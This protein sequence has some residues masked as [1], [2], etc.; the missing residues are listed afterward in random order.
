ME[1]Y[2]YKTSNTPFSSSSSSRVSPLLSGSAVQGPCGA[3]KV[4]RRRCTKSCLLAPY[5]PPTEPMKFINA[6][7]IYGASNIVKCLQELPESKRADA[8]SSMVYEANAR[9]RDPVYGCAGAI[10]HL[11]K[12]LNDVQAELAMTQAEIL[13]MQSQQQ[14]QQQQQQQND[15]ASFLDNRNLGLDW[16]TD[17]WEQK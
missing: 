1:E 11:L 12:R 9:I 13:I 14:Q 4:L 16:E 7:K 17:H 10:S 8:V 3:C 15:N 5:F 2:N 6:H